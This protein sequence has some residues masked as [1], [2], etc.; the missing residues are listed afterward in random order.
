MLHF[1]LKMEAVPS[2]Q[3]FVSY[4]TTGC[5]NPGNLDFRF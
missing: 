1:T 3:T 5:H 4:N 2:S